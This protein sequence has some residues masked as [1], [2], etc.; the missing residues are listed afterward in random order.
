MDQTTEQPNANVDPDE[1]E[2][3]A[4]LADEWWD[5]TGKFRPLH[6]IGP[7]RLEF[8]KANACDI[9][10][11]DSNAIR[12]FDGLSVL[13][14]GCG[15]GL[16]SEPLTRLGAT[17]TG[18]DPA[19][20]GIEAARVH[21]VAGGLDITYRNVTAETLVSE[22][23]TFDIVLALEVI[24]HVPTPSEFVATCARLVAPNGLLVM[25]TINRT[26]KAWGLAI[27]GAEYI[28]RWLPKGTHQWDKFVTPDELEGDITNNGLALND[29][30]G[31]V[32]NPLRDTWTLSDDTDVNYLVAAVR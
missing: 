10:G 22:G 19:G 31:M 11:R 7:A 1:V 15:G 16:I 23:A 24:E 29:R 30:Q 8:I 14:I 28:L 17:V 4:R 6:Q 32:Y 26:L 3:F 5:A 27:V 18:I 12:P 2:R 20:S 13:D 25:S 9:H 21:A